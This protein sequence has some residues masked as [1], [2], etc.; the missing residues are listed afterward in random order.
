MDD[1]RERLARERNR[2]GWSFVCEIRD[3]RT[4]AF[5]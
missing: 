4:M 2:G 1:E 3:A 5:F